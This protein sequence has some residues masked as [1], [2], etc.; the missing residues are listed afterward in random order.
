MICDLLREYKSKSVIFIFL[1]LV[2][3]WKIMNVAFSL[4]A[5]NALALAFY[6]MRAVD[7]PAK[8]EGGYSE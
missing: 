3:M 1:A 2:K 5:L 4:I 6:G 7:P 8:K